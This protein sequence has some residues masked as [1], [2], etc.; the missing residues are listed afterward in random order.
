M[1]VIVADKAPPK[2]KA[3]MEVLASLP[4]VKT[5]RLQGTLGVHEE[6][7]TAVAEVI[8]SFLED[9]DSNVQP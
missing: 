2:S 9:L 6:Y 3:E 5:A 1:L 7:P 4:K 8:V